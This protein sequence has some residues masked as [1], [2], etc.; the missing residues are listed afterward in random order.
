[1]SQRDFLADFN[2]VSDDSRAVLS[3][4][5]RYVNYLKNLVKGMAEYLPPGHPWRLGIAEVIEDVPRALA[6]DNMLQLPKNYGTKEHPCLVPPHPLT[7]E[8]ANEL[9]RLYKGIK[10]SIAWIDARD[11][12]GTS[13]LCKVAEQLRALAK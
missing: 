11:L 10:D 6:D 12:R 4:A 3:E 9:E 5:G 2:R 8:A 7:I 13:D 1:M